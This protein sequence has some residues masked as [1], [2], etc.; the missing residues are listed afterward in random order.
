MI[1]SCVKYF[2]FELLLWLLV[3]GRDCVV[4][5][6]LLCRNYLQL[7]KT[8]Y[9]LHPQFW[10]LYARSFNQWYYCNMYIL[11]VSLNLC[12][13][14][15]LI[16]NLTFLFWV[17]A[18]KD[19]SIWATPMLSA[20]W[21]RTSVFWISLNLPYTTKAWRA[22]STSW[23]LALKLTSESSFCCQSSTRSSEV[24]FLRVRC[25]RQF[26]RSCIVP[27]N[28][29]TAWQ[30]KCAKASHGWLMLRNVSSIWFLY[31]PSLYVIEF[32]WK[33]IHFCLMSLWGRVK[34]RWEIEIERERGEGG[35]RDTTIKTK[36]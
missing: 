6:Q 25:S 29:C 26:S 18:T 16:L 22:C 27:V 32:M 24:V 17:T 20:D 36:Y 33:S 19:L 34:N 1:V 30:K 15:L 12:V 5:E 13:N 35:D 9:F 14:Y 4:Y 31:C 11:T 28:T 2:K 3:S 7:I 8:I 21:S 10:S 23:R